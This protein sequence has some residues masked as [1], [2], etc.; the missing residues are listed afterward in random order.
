MRA[1]SGPHAQAP[2]TETE[3]ALRR[4]WTGLLGR[5]DI[6][7]R[8]DFFSLGGHSLLIM[9]LIPR[10]SDAFGVTIAVEEVFSHPTIAPRRSTLSVFHQLHC[11]VCPLSFQPCTT[12]SSSD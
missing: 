12:T 11:L 8:D 10:L 7:T 2:A 9:R 4:I 6:G 1:P 5:Q 3:G